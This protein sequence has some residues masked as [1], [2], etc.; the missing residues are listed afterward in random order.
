MRSEMS[1]ACLNRE[2]PRRAVSKGVATGKPYFR[3]LLDGL[4]STNFL[5]YFGDETL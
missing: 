5:K 3:A 4:R 1:K 2:E